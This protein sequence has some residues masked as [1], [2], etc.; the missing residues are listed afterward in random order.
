M[1]KEQESDVAMVNIY[2]TLAHLDGVIGSSAVNNHFEKFMRELNPRPVDIIEIGTHNGLSAA[3][4][5]YYAD[6]IFTYDIS[7]RNSEYIWS[8]LK[9]RNRIRAFVGSMDQI[10]YEISY[11]NIDWKIHGIPINI[12]FAFVDGGHELHKLAHDFGL[13]K[14]CGRVLFHDYHCPEIN[15]FCNT[16]G[17]KPVCDGIFAYWEEGVSNAT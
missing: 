10:E 4:M 9:V 16:I 6:R 3:L 17:A 12:D 8:L 7:L 2:N 13:V 15:H 5:S 14:F 1:Q 11:I